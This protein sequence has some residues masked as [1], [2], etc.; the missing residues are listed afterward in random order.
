MERNA[1][2]CRLPKAKEQIT[3]IDYEMY[4]TLFE[5]WVKKGKLAYTHANAFT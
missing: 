2:K 1:C 4:I 3:P 5:K